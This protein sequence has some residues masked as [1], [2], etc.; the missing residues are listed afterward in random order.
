[1]PAKKKALGNTEPETITLQLEGRSIQ[2]QQI[3]PGI[4]KPIQSGG[5]SAMKRTDQVYPGGPTRGELGVSDTMPPLS[6][7]TNKPIVPPPVS[8]SPPAAPF[9]LGAV[10]TLITQGFITDL[11]E[12][13]AQFV[14]RAAFPV[15][16]KM[17]R[18]SSP[19]AAA[20]SAISLPALLT[21]WQVKPA[22][23]ATE[24]GGQF[25]QELADFVEDNFMEDLRL[26]GGQADSRRRVGGP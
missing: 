22:T 5:G 10:G 4:Y 3:S 23:D 24:P 25:A 16:D 19:I 21:D 18:T 15:Y 12:Y 1:M 6:Q 13:N 7:S 9:T 11:T 8:P 14:G 17:R 2:A 20:L 26:P